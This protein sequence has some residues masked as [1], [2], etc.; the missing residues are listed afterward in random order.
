VITLRFVTPS[1]IL[2][3]VS[4]TELCARAYVKYFRKNVFHD[5]LNNTI[6]KHF[7][8]FIVIPMYV[9]NKKVSASILIV[10]LMG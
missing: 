7:A 1:A 9:L 5:C 4:T 3:S 10:H 2:G 8:M 6:L